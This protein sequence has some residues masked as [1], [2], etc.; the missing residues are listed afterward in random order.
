M[1]R[2]RNLIFGSKPQT[3]KP[4]IFITGCSSGVGLSLANH[5]YKMDCYRVVATARA[6]SLKVLREHGLIDHENFLAIPMDVTKT[7]DRDRAIDTVARIWG[8]VDILINNA[9]VSYRAVVED[10]T[11]NDEQK[12]LATNYL[13]PMALIRLVLPYMRHRGRGKIINI[14]SVSGMLAMPTMASYS[15]SKHALEGAS[16]ALWYEMQPLGIDVTLVQPG[17]INSES[18]KKVKYTGTALEHELGRRGPYSDYYTNMAPFIERMMHLSPTTPDD[19][20]KVVYKIIKTQRPGLRVAATLDA[21]FFYYFR[22]LLPRRWL[23][24]VLFR[25]LPNSR[26]WG[27]GY[28]NSRRKK[29]QES[30][31]TSLLRPFR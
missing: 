8:G 14:S 30:L 22:R 6:S 3:Y 2:L 7:R 31:R 16:E 28:S 1:Y 19:V 20:S 12:Q 5:L 17:F 27:K 21:S 29:Q 18:F 15:A 13:G 11:E 9:G 26:H 23:H 4:V 10:M 24:P 25:L